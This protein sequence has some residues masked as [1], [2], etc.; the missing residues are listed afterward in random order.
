MLWVLLCH[1]YITKPIIISLVGE[2]NDLQ[3]EQCKVVHIFHQLMSNNDI[4]REFVLKMRKLHQLEEKELVTVS[5]LKVSDYVK[6]MLNQGMESLWKTLKQDW[7]KCVEFTLKT[8]SLWALKILG[9]HFH[10]KSPMF[11]KTSLDKEVYWEKVVKAACLWIAVPELL[12]KAHTGDMYQFINKYFLSHSPYLHGQYS[13]QFGAIDFESAVANSLRITNVNGPL[14]RQNQKR[15]VGDRKLDYFYHDYIA[16]IERRVE[17]LLYEIAISGVLERKELNRTS[18]PNCE[19]S[20]FICSQTFFTST[21]KYFKQ[22]KDECGVVLNVSGTFQVENDITEKNCSI[23]HQD[24]INKRCMHFM[25]RHLQAL[26]LLSYNLSF[27]RTQPEP[28]LCSNIFIYINKDSSMLQSAADSDYGNDSAVSHTQ[29]N[30]VMYTVQNQKTNRH[31]DSASLETHHLTHSH[32]LCVDAGAASKGTRCPTH[33]QPGCSVHSAVM[34]SPW[35]RK[36]SSVTDK[37][38]VTIPTTLSSKMSSANG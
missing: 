36:H 16:G 7:P 18:S 2:E 13:K 35:M 14:Y 24:R 3:N 12:S 28:L 9:K 34:K 21:S 15:N 26:R 29:S 1:W 27:A 22:P 6:D 4:N 33:S 5:E 30:A 31:S 8:K 10:T 32:P 23:F 37:K 38:T 19:K 11:M 17:Q 20:L 25:D